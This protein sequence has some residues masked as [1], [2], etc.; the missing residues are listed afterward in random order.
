MNEET[1]IQIIELMDDGATLESSPELKGLIEASEE[2]TKFYESL[3]ISESMLQGFF[4]GEKAKEIDKKIDTFIDEHL[5]K[6]SNVSSINFK[7]FIGFAV[8]ASVAV[9]AFTIVKSPSEIIELAAPVQIAYD[10]PAPIIEEVIEEPEPMFVSGS[11]I[12][13]LWSTASQ[14]ANDLDVDRYQVMYALYEA[15]KDFFVNNDI[16]APRADRD[17]FVDLSIIKT[18]DAVYASRE[19]K[20]HIFC[21]C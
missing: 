11:E 10:E 5:E 7:P 2:A 21:R 3:L 19:V 13:T 8:A 6:P 15:N 1:Q 20:R 16:N 4:G 12:E 18:I 17:Y 9:V 14:I